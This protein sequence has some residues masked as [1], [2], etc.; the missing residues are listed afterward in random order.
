[1]WAACDEIATTVLFAYSR[2]HVAGVESSVTRPI[3]LAFPKQDV[4]Y[5]VRASTRR[6]NAG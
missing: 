5:V 6:R 3:T 4:R 2:L 1:M